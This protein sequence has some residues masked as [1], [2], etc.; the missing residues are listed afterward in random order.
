MMGTFSQ[1]RSDAL[2]Q[3][4]Q[5]PTEK[6]KELISTPIDGDTMIGS[7]LCGMLILRYAPRAAV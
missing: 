7:T 1:L 5:C 6:L 4:L 3:F 2:S